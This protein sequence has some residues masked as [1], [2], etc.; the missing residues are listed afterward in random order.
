MR[1]AL[2]IVLVAALAG[3]ATS[4]SQTASDARTRMVGM[5]KEN[6][7]ACMGAPQQRVAEGATEVWR[8][9]S[10]GGTVTAATAT[11][12]GNMAM[13]MANTSARYCIVN[14]VI[15]DGAVTQVNYSG[16]AGSVLAPGEQCAYA[17]QN[18]AR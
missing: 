5:S 10:G 15:R 1:R 8:Y 4:R 2:A 17:V 6:V 11:A 16:P 7:L 14:L 3:C 12:S 18:C 13:G 9:P